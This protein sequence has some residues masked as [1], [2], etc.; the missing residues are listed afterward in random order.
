MAGQRLWTRE[1]WLALITA[2]GAGV[3]LLALRG[4][5][6]VTGGEIDGLIV[7]A[8]ALVTAIA[9]LAVI[10]AGTG[11]R[12]IVI[13]LAVLWVVVALGGL[14]GYMEHHAALK[15]GFGDL[16]ARPPFAPLIFDVLAIAGGAALAM[17]RR[18]AAR[19]AFRP[20]AR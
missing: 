10:A 1:G 15:P 9:T 12:P 14:G 6:H 17:A 20:S 3:V 8:I 5:D 13:G 7:A 2:I 4:A 11:S 18:R 19:E 16:R